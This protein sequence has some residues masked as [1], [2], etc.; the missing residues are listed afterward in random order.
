[1]NT[2][3]NIEAF[4]DLYVVSKVMGHSS[5]NTTMIYLT[6]NRFRNKTIME[7]YNIFEE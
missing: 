5:I 4:L 6:N 2:N 3:F 7:K 1:M